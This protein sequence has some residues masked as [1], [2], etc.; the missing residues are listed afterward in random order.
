MKRDECL[1]T[2]KVLVNGDRASDYGDA[3]ENHQRIA[4]LWSTYLSDRPLTARDVAHMM[5]LLKVARLMHSGNDDCYVDI[6]GYA[7]LAAEMDGRDG[8]NG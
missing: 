7:A 6:S 5:I 1:D 4:S 3:Y 8:R 2:A